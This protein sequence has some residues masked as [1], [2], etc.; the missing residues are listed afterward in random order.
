MFVFV[1]TRA[2]T[3]NYDKNTSL[4]VRTNLAVGHS[5]NI[6]DIFL[7][8]ITT[9]NEKQSKKLKKYIYIYFVFMLAMLFLQPTCYVAT[10]SELTAEV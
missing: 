10:L 8:K 4:H 5:R 6:I 3:L 7:N 9:R 1:E 2:R